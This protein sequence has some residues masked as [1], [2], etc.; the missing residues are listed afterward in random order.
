MARHDAQ[1]R[2]GA[3][4]LAQHHHADPQPLVGLELLDQLDVE[5]RHLGRDA[6]L[7]R[8]GEPGPVAGPH[9]GGG[10]GGGVPQFTEADADAIRAQ[11]GGIAAVAPQGRANATVI[12]NGR[13]WSTN[14][15]GTTNVADLPEF[16]S[17]KTTRMVDGVAE[18]G[19]FATDFTL[20]EIKTLRAIQPLSDRD[21]QYN[22]KFQIPTLD[23][24][25][26]L[27]KSEGSKVGRTVGVYPETKHPTFHANLGL[28][29][30]DRL[31]A[32][33]AKYGYT[34]KASPVI[35]QSF[36][37]SNL[38]YLRSKTQIRLVQLVDA[39]DVKADLYRFAD[40]A[41]VEN[42]R[43][44]VPTLTP[45]SPPPTRLTISAPAPSASNS[46]CQTSNRCFSSMTGVSPLTMYIPPSHG[47]R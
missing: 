35:V 37:V 33:L 32:T 23:E 19:W 13:N 7:V 47:S 10:G 42:R 36:E 9:V 24:V 12:G 14:I 8:L 18:T 11:I 27:A 28:K 34:T 6:A 1:R 29:L 39:D 41:L 38:K 3:V 26:D 21:P 25:L 2:V 17:R 31:L 30:E 45:S 44:G 43:R 46:S 15:T 4:A 16:A 20:A 40:A 22:G 5:H